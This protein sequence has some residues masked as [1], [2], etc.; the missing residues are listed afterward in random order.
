M[1]NYGIKVSKD[2]YDVK[3]CT[4]DQL[5]MTSKLN[6]LKTKAVGTLTDTSV[7]HGLS[8][9]PIFFVGKRNVG[10]NARSLPIGIDTDQ[11]GC[12]ATN[13]TVSNSFR[14]YIFY[15]QAI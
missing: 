3:T 14:Y 7:A 11:A 6:L 8:Y 12:N 15:Q 5:V 2:G 9:V 13:L 4:E 1:A 10:T